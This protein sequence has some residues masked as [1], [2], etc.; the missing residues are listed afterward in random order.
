MEKPCSTLFIEFWTVS[1]YME[2]K[3]FENTVLACF[4]INWK[5]LPTF[6]VFISICTQVVGEREEAAIGEETPEVHTNMPFLDTFQ[7]CL[8]I[9][10]MLIKIIRHTF[11]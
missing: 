11:P 2:E 10:L 6:D 7:I 8:I 4:R 5:A 1:T 3:L 9:V